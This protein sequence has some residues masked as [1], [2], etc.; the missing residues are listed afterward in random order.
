MTPPQFEALKTLFTSGH[1]PEIWG[2]DQAGW[3]IGP[4]FVVPAGTKRS[5][6]RRGWIKALR[7]RIEDGQTTEWFGAT[8]EG[9]RAYI[10]AGGDPGQHGRSR[11]ARQ[12]RR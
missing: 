4:L 10:A 8:D 6:E 11:R 1:K 12:R 5:L 2:S 3:R 9:R 7:A